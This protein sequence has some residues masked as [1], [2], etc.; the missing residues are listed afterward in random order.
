MRW[1]FFLSDVG[2]NMLMKIN[3]KHSQFLISNVSVIMKIWNLVIAGTS[4]WKKFSLVTTRIRRLGLFWKHGTCAA[5]RIWTSIL[6]S[7][8]LVCHIQHI[9]S[10]VK[11]IYFISTLAMGVIVECDGEGKGHS[12]VGKHARCCFKACELDL[13]NT[14]EWILP[15]VLQGS[16]SWKLVWFP[17]VQARE[18][19]IWRKFYTGMYIDF[20]CMIQL[21][22][23]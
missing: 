17:K 4:D 7:E 3:G 11:E 8:R 20:F 14:C 23:M 9:Y 1:Q 13:A 12:V 2:S 5:S 16:M 15:E 18:R 19:A 6:R 21:C 22:F 10:H